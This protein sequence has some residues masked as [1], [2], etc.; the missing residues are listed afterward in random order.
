MGI[1]NIKFIAK[2][3]IKGNKKSTLVLALMIILVIFLSLISSF[4]VTIT[5]AVNEY[6]EDYRARLL[7]VDSL[8]TE[9]TDDVIENIKQVD[10]V[11]DIYMLQGMRDQVFDILDV[12]DENGTYEEL[13]K[14]LEKREGSVQA[15]SLIGS[16]KR[17]VIAGKTLNESPTFSC[18]IPSLFY[19]FDDVYSSTNGTMQ[20]LAYIDGKSLVGKT[21]TVKAFGEGYYVS[22]NYNND[23][24]F[25]NEFFY[26]PALEYKLKIVGV[27]YSSPTGAGYYNDIYV[28]EETGKLIEKMAFD[29]GSYNSPLAEKWYNTPSLRTHYLL[30]DDYENI[31]YVYNTLTDM[32]IDCAHQPEMG[33]KESVLII[34]N[35]LSIAGI[36]LIAATFILCIINLIQSTTS[37]IKDR[38][39][40]IGLLKAIGYKNRQ[41]FACLCYEQLDLTIKG[42]LIG[43]GFS[44]IFI[45]IANVINSH[46]TYVD[47]LYIVNWHDYL[48]FLTISLGIAVI[49]P[50]ICQ[51]ITLHK[52][53]RIQP[54]DAMCLE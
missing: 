9:L 11:E 36:F 40:E 24:F 44:A 5:N 35:I 14:Q 19:P 53:T 42:F 23:G 47:R 45:F 54:K 46:R 25:E 52:L 49:V 39:S 41:V 3:N 29:E 22:F 12:S 6:K 37:S 15:W 4:S 38:R 34:S 28:S 31:D 10:H 48:M 18:I 32:G 17:S 43:G 2:A 20:N 51:L 30:V 13:Q 8:S 27:Y 33:I 26:L 50:L 7:Q 16:E 21:I 1:K